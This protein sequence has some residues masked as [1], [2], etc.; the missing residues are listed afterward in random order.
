[1]TKQEWSLLTK[2]YENPKKYSDPNGLFTKLINEITSSNNGRTFKEQSY[3]YRNGVKNVPLCS[4]G[5]YVKFQESLYVWS[6]TCGQKCYLTNKTVN[7]K[8]VVINGTIYT[9]LKEASENYKEGTLINDLYDVT[10]PNVTYLHDHNDTCSENLSSIP[11]LLDK[12]WLIQKKEE[13]VTIK[14]IANTLGT[15]REKV[16]WAFLFH[17]IP[18]EYKQLTPLTEEQLENREQFI[19]D[20][21]AYGTEKLSK[22]YS[23]S[24]TTILT[25]AK[26]YGCPISRTTSA[27]E[28]HIKEYIEELGFYVEQSNRSFGVEL[29]LYVP[30]ANLAIELDGLFWHS[31]WDLNSINP[32]KHKKKYDICSRNNVTLLRFTDYETTNKLDLVKSMIHSRLGLN[33]RLYARSCYVKEIDTTEAKKFLESNHISG[34]A[35][36]SIKLGL[37]R[38][39]DLVMVMTFGKPRFSKNY[40]WE[41]IRMASGKKLTIV[42]GASKLLTYFRTKNPGSIMSYSDNRVGNGNTYKKLGFVF[43]K[44]TT[45][46]YF[47]VKNNELYS[48]YQFQKSKIE[49]LCTVYDTNK[50]EFENAIANNFGRYWDCGNKIWVLQ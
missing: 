24:P 1:M 2:F 8:E 32:N 30:S 27:I 34:Y 26:K 48:R 9:S 47:Y 42:G 22:L 37:Y 41:V 50:S 33:T 17:G 28:L 40:D 11:L 18:R 7:K 5:N 49:K 43:V 16:T 10:K 21:V 23:C 38:D 25:T 13:R 14:E 20:F 15:S 31:E 12:E 4:C 19:E 35:N 45:P 44:E 46:G 6:K 39:N 29:D 36:A 3:M